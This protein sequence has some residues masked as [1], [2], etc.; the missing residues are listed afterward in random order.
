MKNLFFYFYCNLSFPLSS[1]TFRQ[2]RKAFPTQSDENYEEI[3]KPG[4][5]FTWEDLS[6]GVQFVN[7]AL[8]EGTGLSNIVD[9][10]TVQ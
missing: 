6:N 2:T 3:G 9:F 8:K 5:A 4:K 10:I 7:C 1:D